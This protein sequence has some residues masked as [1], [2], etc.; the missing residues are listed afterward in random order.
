VGK[1]YVIYERNKMAKKIQVG[2][3][4][5]TKKGSE[6]EVLEYTSARKVMI[7][8]WRKNAKGQKKEW[9]TKTVRAESLRKQTV[10]HPFEISVC[11]IGYLGGEQYGS[12]GLYKHVYASWVRMFCRC[13]KRNKKNGTK[14]SRVVEQWHNYQNFA[15]WF[16]SQEGWEN[17]A[18]QLDKDGKCKGNTVYGPDFCVLVSAELNSIFSIKSPITRLKKIDAYYKGKQS[19]RTRCEQIMSLMTKIKIFY[20]INIINS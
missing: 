9:V 17:T 1:H 5:Y 16:T 18:L 11:G 2:D 7:R 4:F 12:T 19:K 8:M 13:N 10:K 20:Q 3:L 15:E 6:I 14:E